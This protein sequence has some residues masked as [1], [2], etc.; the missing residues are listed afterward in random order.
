MQSL[1]GSVQRE[2]KRRLFPFTIKITSTVPLEFL[3]WLHHC[4]GSRDVMTFCSVQVNSNLDLMAIID[5][6]DCLR[7][8]VRLTLTCGFISS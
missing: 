5:C 8:P 6:N 3:L 4:H 2:R 7:Y 1:L